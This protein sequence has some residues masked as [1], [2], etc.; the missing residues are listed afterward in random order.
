M[1][2]RS[3]SLSES[4]EHGL[5]KSTSDKLKSISLIYQEHA[6][7][8]QCDQ[9]IINYGYVSVR[10]LH[11][12]E[13]EIYYV[14]LLETE[15][16][17]F[18]KSC[19]FETCLFEIDLKNVVTFEK[20][21]YQDNIFVMQVKNEIFDIKCHNIHEFNRW[22]VSLSDIIH[23]DKLTKILKEGIVKTKGR[24]FQRYSREYYILT[25]KMELH[26]FQA[27]K[28][29]NEKNAKSLRKIDLSHENNVVI[30]DFYDKSSKNFKYG[31]QIVIN[32]GKEK[33]CFKT[34]S[35]HDQA[36]WIHHL[37]SR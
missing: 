37:N 21:P 28:D 27:P 24:F 18:Y 32:K 31:I 1:I 7:E 10:H 23:A 11:P 8:N 26:I 30:Q 16:L 5:V 4:L 25:N 12:I 6:I 2:S 35:Q 3:R 36:E 13:F 19:D 20:H 29:G 14:V 17:Q 9:N 22:F 34:S 15:F 33:Y